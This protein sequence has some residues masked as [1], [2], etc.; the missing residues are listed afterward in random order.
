[1]DLCPEGERFFT[2]LVHRRPH[3]WRENDLPAAWEL[4]E[5][6]GEA[7]MVEAFRYCLA[8]GAIGGEYL[9]AWARGVVQ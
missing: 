3:T 6:Q 7:R 5:H 8:R 4:F 9:R 2:E 1:M